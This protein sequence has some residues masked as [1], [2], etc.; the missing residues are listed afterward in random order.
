MTSTGP[1]AVHPLGRAGGNALQCH[2]PRVRPPSSPL[3]RRGHDSGLVPDFWSGKRENLLFRPPCLVP[4]VSEDPALGEV[5]DLLSDEYARAI[6][7]AASEQPMSAKELAE[8]CDMSEPTVYRRI[9]QLREHDLVEEQTKIETGGNDYKLYVT[10]LSGFSL[11]L[12]DGSFESSLERA[13]GPA[14]P[15]QDEA[16]TADRFKKMWENL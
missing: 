16:D 11:R 13:A 5:L 12:A 4:Y 10:T 15:G 14:F 9:S 7:A 3:A 1:T 8:Q 2:R 6:L